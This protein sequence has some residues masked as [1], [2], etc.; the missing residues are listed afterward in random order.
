VLAERLAGQCGLPMA[1][2]KARV[3]A[4]AINARP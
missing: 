4:L 2:A 3:M 1:V